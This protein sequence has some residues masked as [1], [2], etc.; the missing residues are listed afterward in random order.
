ML[1]NLAEVLAD[2]QKHHYAVGMFNTV[3]IEMARGV[4]KA[5]EDLNSP[6]IIGSAEV[7]L[8]Y[9]DLETLA[10][11]L[12]PLAKKAKVPVVLHYDHGL[13]EELI[14]KALSCG[15]TSVMYDCSVMSFNENA[16]RCAR[17]KQIARAFGAS[18]EAE[19]GHVGSGAA[20]SAEATTD[21][22]HDESI[23]T[24]P[25][26]AKA[27]ADYTGVDALAVAIGSAHGPYAKTPVL[28]I[29][30]LRQIRD[31]V[32]VPLVLHGGSGLTNADFRNCID[33]GICKINIFTDIDRGGASGALSA[34][35]KGHR[36]LTDLLPEIEKGVYN[37]TY[38]K[39]R[40]F[41]GEHA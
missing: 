17:I 32:S 31:M 8:K 5:A 13:T 1:T 16:Q 20:G 9:A 7:L 4:I 26:E 2:A 14:V 18:I 39:I 29:E 23:Y 35:N 10:S 21:T 24:N 11:F 36:N 41:R 25:A 15:F 27:F 34:L 3:N 40:L 38:D 28:D 6:V 22:A 30:R 12:I 33:N 19:L 37:A